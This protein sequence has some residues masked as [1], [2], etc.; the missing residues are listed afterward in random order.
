MVDISLILLI[1]P[2]VFSLVSN[3]LWSVDTTSGSSV[4]F[5]PPPAAFGI[6]WAI[7]YL[8]LGIAWYME[9]QS[10][11]NKG[12]ILLAYTILNIGL[13]AWLFVYNKLKD[14]KLGIYVIGACI[15]LA[16]VCYTV[17]QN[18]VVKTMLVPLITWLLL[19]T[20]LN[21]FEV[22]SLQSS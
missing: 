11:S 1:L 3:K 4:K 5:R 9:Y 17:S 6:V 15:G 2:T 22:Q 10:N 18:T 7:L 20:M 12:V 21:A 16:L 14:K 19:A 13:C 8:L